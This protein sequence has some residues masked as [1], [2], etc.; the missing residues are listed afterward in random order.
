MKLKLKGFQEDYTNKLSMALRMAAREA[1]ATASSQAVIF[2][3][4]TGSGKTLMVTAAIEKLMEGDGEYAADPRATFLWLS[5]QPEIN[6]QTRRKM[7]ETSNLNSSQLIVVD[8]S[9]DQ[10]SFLPGK[11]YFLN[12][13][14]LGKEKQLVTHS[15]DRTFTIWE[16]ISN[17]LRNL[18]ENFFVFID[19]AH[20]GMAVNPRDQKEAASIVQKFIVGIEGEISPV[21][22]I[23]GISAT[24]DRFDKLIQGNLRVRRPVIVPPEAVRAS[25]LLKNAIRLFYPTKNQ[26]TDMTMLRAAAKSWNEYS[27]HWERYCKAQNE[28][29]VKPIL[30]VQVQDGTADNISNTNIEEVISV[31]DE[32]GSLPVNAF[33]HT[34]QE[35]IDLDF[36]G[37]KLRYLHPADINMDPD[38]LVVLFKTSL[39]TGWDCPRAEVM[40][41]F[42]KAIDATLIA[43][44]VGRMVRTPLAR[45][46]SS[47][48]FLNMVSLYLPHFDQIGLG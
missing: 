4:P 21:P 11:I 6:E 9:F 16:T 41:S 20:R 14:K 26:P 15:D 25:G 46:V 47:D 32:V 2:S 8:A 22:I 40:M 43:Q 19:E 12:T 3:S 42:R 1:A 27:N 35:G 17:T 38:V 37:K 13:Q 29:N 18:P 45:H 39:N 33:A 7:I 30:V 48:D 36:G 24:P 10:E 31:I 28:R 44:L 34:F 5:D 23:I